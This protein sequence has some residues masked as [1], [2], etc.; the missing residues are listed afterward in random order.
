MTETTTDGVILAAGAILLRGRGHRREVC[1]VHRPANQDWSVPKGKPLQGEQLPV[2]AVREVAEET[3]ILVRL[4][5]PLDEI[6]YP[7]GDREKAVHFWIGHEITTKKRP[8]DG[9]VDE[10]TWLPVAQA[11]QQLT[12]RDEVDLLTRAIHQ[13]HTTPL[14]VLRH[15]QAVQRKDWAKDDTKRPLDPHGREQS[16]HLVHLLEAYG[17]KNLSS[18][19]STRCKAT[20]VPYA[21]QLGVEIKPVSLL[22]EEVGEKHLRGVERY[23]VGLREKVGEKKV[24]TVICGHRPVLPAML[25]GLGIEYGSMAPGA[26]VVAH[27]DGEGRVVATEWH[28]PPR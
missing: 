12:Y 18:S 26:C 24:P 17:V 3:G 23:I 14:I 16:L 5:T 25:A 21:R 4:G 6:R 1:V 27:V 7:V 19:T 28:K 9:E 22:S 13:P 10:V 2:T 8:P 20:L 15:A 11:M